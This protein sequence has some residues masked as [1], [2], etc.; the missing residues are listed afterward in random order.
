MRFPLRHTELDENKSEMSTVKHF[1]E[2]NDADMDDR[3]GVARAGATVNG[4]PQIGVLV[5]NDAEK[6]RQPSPQNTRRT[7]ERN[8]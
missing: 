3:A 6:I 2:V 5:K 7:C 4:S 1:L 8:R